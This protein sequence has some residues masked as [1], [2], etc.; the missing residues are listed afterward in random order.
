MR[1]GGRLGVG[2][3]GGD[4]FVAGAHAL[5]IQGGVDAGCGGGEGVR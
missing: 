1:R 2:R 3:S 4:A 5:R